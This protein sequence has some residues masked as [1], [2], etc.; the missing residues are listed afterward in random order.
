[1]K[2][3][4]LISLIIGLVIVIAGLAVALKPQ[5]APAIASDHEEHEPKVQICQ[6]NE[7]KDEYKAKEVKESDVTDADFTYGGPIKEDGKIDNKD[8]QADDWCNENIPTYTYCLESENIEVKLNEEA[9]KGAV[10][11]KCAEPVV[12]SQPSAPSVPQAP[13]CPDGNTTNVVANPQVARGVKDVNGVVDLSKATVTWFKTEGDNAS[14]YYKEVNASNWQHSVRDI[15]TT[16]LKDNFVSVTVNDLDPNLGYTFGIEQK[17]GCSGGQT[18][19]AGIIDGPATQLFGLSF[20][21]WG[22]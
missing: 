16:D 4:I 6:Y 1:M 12:E 9:P 17:T 7:D 19:I 15:K 20:Y 3:N 22:K 11:G 5:P 10:E 2:G 8:K 21:E 13:I 18:I 14:I